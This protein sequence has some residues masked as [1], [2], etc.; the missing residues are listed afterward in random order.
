MEGPFVVQTDVGNVTHH[1]AGIGKGRIDIGNVMADDSRIKSRA[2][3]RSDKFHQIAGADRFVADNIDFLNDRI[4]LNGIV[5]DNAFRN[6]GKGRF[7]R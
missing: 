2:R 5:Q 4:H 7:N 3:R 1:I 6:V